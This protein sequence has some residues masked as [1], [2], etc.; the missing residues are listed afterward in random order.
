MSHKPGIRNVPPPPNSKAGTPYT[1]FIPREELGDFAS[2]TPG[3]FGPSPG[4]AADAARAAPE[5]PPEPTAAEWQA[6]VA[7]A[8]QAGYQDGY[9]DGLV[10]LEE[11]KASFAQQATAQV[12]ALLEAF[13]RQTERLDTRLADA[14]ARTALQ[15]ARQV[16]RHELASSPTLVAAVATEAVNAVLLSARHVVVHVNP[17]DLPLV[18]EGASEALEARGA[19]LVADAGL[20]RGDVLV[21]SDV[22]H[23]DARVETRWA[24]ALAALG[25]A[26]PA[27]A[28]AAAAAGK[29]GEPGEE[30][31]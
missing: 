31:P 10:A 8:R 20:Q 12:G 23:T 26:E 18:A 7:A 13:D 17:Q 28:A 21:D 3:S 6:R 14:V 19:R 29:A 24:Q 4:S 11:F 1:R 16:L 2:W 9:R 22:G 25:M 27:A 15:L 30:A 5:P